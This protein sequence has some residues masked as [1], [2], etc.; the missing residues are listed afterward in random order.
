VKRRNY[1]CGVL[2][3]TGAIFVLFIL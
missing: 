3:Y 1:V 2:C